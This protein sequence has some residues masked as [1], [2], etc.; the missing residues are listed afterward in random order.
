MTVIRDMIKACLLFFAISTSTLAV[1]QEVY[2]FDNPEYESRYHELTYELRCLVCQNQNIADSNASLA[3]DLRRKTYELITTG[4]S[5]DEVV[6][7]MVKRY[8]EFVL[9]KPRLS[10]STMLLWAGPF[11]LLL[12]AAIAMYKFVRRNRGAALSNQAG[13]DMPSE[14]ERQTA[15]DLLNNS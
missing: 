10:N 8:G 14:Q 15:R 4:K 13:A 3:Q 5:N 11:L 9:Y 2:E 6:D 12:I 7:F 1:N